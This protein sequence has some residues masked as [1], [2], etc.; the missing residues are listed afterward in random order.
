MGDG[1]LLLPKIDLDTSFIFNRS[2]G[3]KAGKLSGE[4]RAIHDLYLRREQSPCLANA[5]HARYSNSGGVCHLGES[6]SI[7]HLGL[8]QREQGICM[9]GC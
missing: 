1:D 8:M 7:L 5:G 6:S 3:S 2:S 9:D 4:H